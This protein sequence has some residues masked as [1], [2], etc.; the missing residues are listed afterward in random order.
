[1]NNSLKE[2]NPIQQQQLIFA[3]DSEVD[4]SSDR[5]WYQ[6]NLDIAVPLMIIAAGFFQYIL[7]KWLLPVSNDIIDK[8]EDQF[9]SQGLL[10]NPQFGVVIMIIGATLLILF[11]IHLLL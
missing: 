3:I 5:E 8:L 9:P 6:D 4:F 11:N 2:N 10:F 1:M 7:R